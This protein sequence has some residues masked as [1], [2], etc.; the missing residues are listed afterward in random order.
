M[1]ALL[2]GAEVSNL[3]MDTKVD[4]HTAQHTQWKKQMKSKFKVESKTGR[5]FEDL[6]KMTTSVK[7]T[8][9]QIYPSVHSKKQALENSAHRLNR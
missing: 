5:K 7:P 4:A 9:S 2:R 6:R 3:S 1:I 8:L